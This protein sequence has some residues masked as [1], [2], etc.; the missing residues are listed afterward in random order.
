MCLY[1][2]TG[3]STIS[4]LFP[5]PCSVSRH[6]ADAYHIGERLAVLFVYSLLAFTSLCWDVSFTWFLGCL[7]SVFSLSLLMQTI[8]VF[9]TRVTH[10]DY[11]EEISNLL[12][13]LVFTSTLSDCRSCEV[14]SGSSQL[15]IAILECLP[16]DFLPQD[17]MT[18]NYNSR[19][20]EGFIS[21]ILH[22]ILEFEKFGGQ[23]RGT[24]I[25]DFSA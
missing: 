24:A 25:S 19:F 15:W 1:R 12:C 4:S 11:P 13:W 6:K 9:V 5:P 7:C 8:Q 21:N 2:H 14:H 16:L 10:S 20:S 17:S 23:R 22:T 3:M 18:L